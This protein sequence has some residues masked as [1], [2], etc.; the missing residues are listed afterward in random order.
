MELH[1]YDYFIS[2]YPS[3]DLHGEDTNTT[4]Y[5]LNSFIDDNYLLG[6]ENIVIIHGIGAGILRKKVLEILRA[7]KKVSSFKTGILNPGLTIV[8]LILDK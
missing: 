8:K 4:E 6:N 1:N 2:K 3:I 5:I 7:N